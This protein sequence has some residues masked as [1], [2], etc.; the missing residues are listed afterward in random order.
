[1][2]CV[3]SAATATAGLRSCQKTL[4]TAWAS[5]TAGSA[6]KASITVPTVFRCVASRNREGPELNCE[7][8]PAALQRKKHLCP[9]TWAEIS[10]WRPTPPPA[11]SR[12]VRFAHLRSRWRRP[13][14][15]GTQRLDY[16][17][18]N[19]RKLRPKTCDSQQTA[20]AG[21]APGLS[22]PHGGPSPPP[23]TGPQHSLRS[24][25]PAQATDRKTAPPN[26]HCPRALRF[27]LHS[28]YAEVVE[29]L[30]R[31]GARG[32]RGLRSRAAA[33]LRLR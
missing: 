3:V 2:Q 11:A 13:V 29:S 12:N 9:R 33:Q 7:P 18:N 6:H 8:T 19:S 16:S 32:L 28:A 21:R 4:P 27:I 10:R 26:S 20:T 15:L 22:S 1:M 31:R 17:L 30:L 25:A 23:A 14:P 5:A 24:F